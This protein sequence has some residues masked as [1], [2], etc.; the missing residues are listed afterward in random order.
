MKDGSYLLKEWFNGGI[1]EIG[2]G[3]YSIISKDKKRGVMNSNGEIVVSDIDTSNKK[4]SDA[5]Y[6]PFYDRDFTFIR[7]SDGITY[8]YSKH[9]YEKYAP[10]SISELLGILNKQ[11]KNNHQQAIVTNM[12]HSIK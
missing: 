2:N 1:S 4:T 9:T 10:W 5:Q 3:F 8:A 12:S 6:T 11:I 7:H